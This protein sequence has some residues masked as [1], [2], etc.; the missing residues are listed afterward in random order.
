MWLIWYIDYWS[1]WDIIKLKSSVQK[2]RPQIYQTSWRL[3]FLWQVG[4]SFHS[5][6]CY[7]I[8]CYIY[9]CLFKMLWLFIWFLK[10]M[11]TII[12][13]ILGYSFLYTASGIETMGLIFSWWP[14]INISASLTKSI[15]KPWIP[16]G[17]KLFGWCK[18]WLYH[19]ASLSI[20][21]IC[22]LSIFQASLSVLTIADGLS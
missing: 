7:V 3:P 21:K 13:S 20:Y 2:C 18:V 8:Y 16:L 15:L 5:W 11:C 4:L 19:I 14:H 1:L 12:F 9:L 17:E 22:L 10:E 6:V